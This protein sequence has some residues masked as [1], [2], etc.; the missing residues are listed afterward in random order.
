[1]PPAF[2]DLRLIHTDTLTHRQMTI[3]NANFLHMHTQLN[4]T[5]KTNQ[6]EPITFVSINFGYPQ[7]GQTVLFTE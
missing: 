3:I 6:F 2:R 7:L 4:H 1:M 5:Q